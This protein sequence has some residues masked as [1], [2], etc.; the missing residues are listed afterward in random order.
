MNRR[1]VKDVETHGRDVRKYSFT[2]FECA[3]GSR[4]HFIP[5]AEARL[6][7]INRDSQLFV[8][9]GIASVCITGS[10][11]GKSL[12]DRFGAE[13]ARRIAQ[14]G[15]VFAEGSFRCVVQEFCANLDVDG[16]VL[17]GF[18]ST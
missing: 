5:R 1:K 7:G 9:C 13:L 12:V 15:S 6:Y 17:V 11:K 14:S 8:V 4:K 16:N 18:D 3:A 10:E 2:V